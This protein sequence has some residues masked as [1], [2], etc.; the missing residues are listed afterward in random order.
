MSGIGQ[1]IVFK[2][3][4]LTIDGVD[5]STWVRECTLNLTTEDIESTG[6]QAAGKEF[7]SGDRVD[8]L[9]VKFKQDFSA[10]AVDATLFPIFESGDAVEFTLRHASSAVSA[11]NP[12]YRGTIRLNSYQPFTGARNTLLEPQITMPVNGA[13]TRH[14]T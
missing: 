6:M 12:E 14:T 13:V 8:S 1:G 9:D 11:T 3:A 2:D 5:L 7:Q 10:A 4:H